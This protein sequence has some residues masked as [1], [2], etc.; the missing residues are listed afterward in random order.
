MNLAL[1]QEMLARIEAGLKAAAAIFADY[2]PGAV[3]TQF[4]SGDDPVTAADHAVDAGLRP[5]LQ[6]EGEGWLSEETVD[7]SDRMKC[8]LCWIV[9][10]L[11]GTREFVKGIPEWCVSIGLVEDGRPVAGGIYNPQTQETFLGSVH[12]GV[13]YNGQP[14]KP[15]DATTL[16]G[17]RVLA[18][19]S[20]I[21]R[22]E[23]D[24]FASAGFVTVP[25]GSVAYKLARVAA[26]LDEVTFTLVPKNEWD[27]A[28]G[29]ALIESAGG[30]ARDLSNSP[31]PFNRKSTLLTGMFAG[32]P[33]VQAELTALL[34]PHIGELAAR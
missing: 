26:G 4:K 20:E 3:E 10:P 1:E 28:A 9:D 5:L 25:M 11:D 8:A 27:V 23:W 13:T 14:A 34:A 12:T 17:A 30:F 7:D 22:G 6:R 32:C 24:G 15:K 33:G 2:T 18:S 29:V 19:R 16:K 21:G 31:I